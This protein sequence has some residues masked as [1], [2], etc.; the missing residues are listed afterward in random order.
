M[1]D[2]CSQAVRIHVRRSQDDLVDSLRFSARFYYF[3]WL[4][5]LR[6]SL[7]MHCYELLV[8]RTAVQQLVQKFMPKTSSLI[9]VCFVGFEAMA[10]ND[11]F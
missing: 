10:G 3:G 7:S 9:Y 1:R 4:H 11:G 6:E 8:N 2:R 5:Y